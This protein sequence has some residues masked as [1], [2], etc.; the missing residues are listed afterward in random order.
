MTRAMQVVMMLALGMALGACG[1]DDVSGDTGDGGDGGDGGLVVDGGGGDVIDKN[2][3]PP[4]CGGGGA[5]DLDHTAD[6]A[7]GKLRLCVLTGE[8]RFWALDAK[9][10]PDTTFKKSGADLYFVPVGGDEQMVSG[11]ILKGSA[12]E[13]YSTRMLGHGGKGVQ[14]ARIVLGTEEIQ[15]K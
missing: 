3:T 6:R 10:K 15:F 1:N 4:G 7:G 5:A 11:L 2:W 8:V 13:G 9:G 14:T 12:G